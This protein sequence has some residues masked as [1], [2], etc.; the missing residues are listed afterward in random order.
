MKKLVDI[1]QAIVSIRVDGSGTYRP[2]V[3]VEQLHWLNLPLQAVV[4]N[5]SQVQVTYHWVL[6]P[7]KEQQRAVVEALIRLNTPPPNVTFTINF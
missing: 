5:E 4:L 6:P 1:T 2:Q 7:S 3:L